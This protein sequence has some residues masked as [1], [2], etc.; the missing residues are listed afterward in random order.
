MY[1]QYL[2]DNRFTDDNMNVFFEEDGLWYLNI[3][4]N[5]RS[6]NESD[7]DN[8]DDYLQKDI[9]FVYDN[10][11]VDSGKYKYS[12]DGTEYE[13]LEEAQNVFG[14]YYSDDAFT[15]DFEW[16]DN[17]SYQAESEDFSWNYLIWRRQVLI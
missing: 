17:S 2:I 10:E 4:A 13:T 8:E 7:E 15:H 3:I 6:N 14:Q 1:A 12:V 9:E 16:T 5:P 11:Y